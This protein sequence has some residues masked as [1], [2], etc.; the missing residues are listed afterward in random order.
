MPCPK[1]E[2]WMEETIV[3]LD[4]TFKDSLKQLAAPVT[5]LDSQQVKEWVAGAREIDEPFATA[6][7]VLV[8]TRSLGFDV[9][10]LFTQD[11]KVSTPPRPSIL[12]LTNL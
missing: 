2:V 1:L 12:D 3:P 5:V 11:I 4:A 6:L 9:G 10:G 7:E 8:K